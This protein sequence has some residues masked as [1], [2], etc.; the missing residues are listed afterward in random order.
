MV[1][2]P[3]CDAGLRFEVESQQMACDHCGNRFDVESTSDNERFDAKGHQLLD[4][5]IFACP[6]CG[7]ELAVNSENDAVGFCPYCGG[8][9]ML[10]DRIRQSWVPDGIIPF[11]VSK[12][13]CKQSY[14]DEV[15]RHP[16]VSNKYRDPNLIESFRG[17]YM[18]YWRFEGRQDKPYKVEGTETLDGSSANKKIRRTF[19]QWYNIDY[20]ITGFSH[21]ASSNFDDHTSEHIA[22]YHDA[23]IVKFHP[24]YLSG[25]YAE[26]GDMDKDT[27]ERYAKERCQDYTATQLPISMTNEELRNIETD[28]S[29]LSNALYPVWFMSYRRGDKISYAAVNGETGKVSAD[30][31]LS[32]LKIVGAAL[33]LAAVIFALLYVAMGFLP[34]IK[35]TG[36]LALSAVIAFASACFLSES[37]L[38]TLSQSLRLETRSKS[39]KTKAKSNPGTRSTLMAIVMTLVAVFG[40]A[41]FVTDGSYQGS[42]RSLGFYACVIGGVYLLTWVIS[43]VRFM[44]DNKEALRESKTSQLENGIVETYSKYKVLFTILKVVICATC[45]IALFLGISESAG[46]LASYALCVVLAIEVLAYAAAQIAFQTTIAEH[47]PPQMAKGG[48][49]YDAH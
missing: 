24:G 7:A 3:T 5:Y 48:A 45:V 33:V 10:F 29:S 44:I 14:V 4:L 40:V 25:F 36:V 9:S 18:P 2:C 22:P 12:E 42:S 32:P 11:K 37:N 21:D 47:R 30:L 20:T 41:L 39:G 35:A 34:S 31:P 13:Q 19:E 8:T 17:I 43:Q 16:F 49:F 46:K 1:H 15:R 23:E 6:D 26:I 38:G 27:Y 28:I